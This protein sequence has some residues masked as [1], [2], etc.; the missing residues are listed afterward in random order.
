MDDGQKRREAGATG[1]L[2]RQAAL[3]LPDIA[4]VVAAITESEL[5]FV[6]EISLNKSLG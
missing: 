2:L 5:G 6:S 1:S 3:H 4:G